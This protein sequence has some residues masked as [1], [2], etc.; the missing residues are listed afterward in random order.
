MHLFLAHHLHRAIH[1]IAD[2][3]FDIAAHVADLGELGGLDLDEGRIG[4][5]GQPAGDFGFAHPGRADHQNILGGNFV[6]QFRRHPHPPPAVAQGNGHGALGGIL[7]D[8]VLVQFLSD[9]S[10]VISDM[11]GYRFD[12]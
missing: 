11:R 3:G 1:Q 9:F 8:D 10:G 7:A 2:D 5:L 6:A 12:G 4:Q